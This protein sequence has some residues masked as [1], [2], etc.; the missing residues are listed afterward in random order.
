MLELQNCLLM[1][2]SVIALIVAAAVWAVL[3]KKP[4]VSNSLRNAGQYVKLP[5]SVHSSAYFDCGT[6]PIVDT[7]PNE[8]R[9]PNIPCSDAGPITLPNAADWFQR[10]KSQSAATERLCR[11]GQKGLTISPKGKINP[12]VG[13]GGCGTPGA[14]ATWILGAVTSGVERGLIIEPA[15]GVFARGELN[16]LHTAENNSTGIE[17][18]FHAESVFFLSPYS[19]PYAL[20]PAEVGTPAMS[21]TSLITALSPE[22][23]FSSDGAS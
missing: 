11:S 19:S 21:I 2:T 1:S 7:L 9:R 23:G 20:F 6:T 18:F 15:L 5:S 8:G 14:T 3:L 17:K 12:I 16:C 10:W 22:S 13:G 4:T